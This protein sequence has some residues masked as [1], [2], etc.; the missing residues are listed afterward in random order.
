MAKAHEELKKLLAEKPGKAFALDLTRKAYEWADRI[1]DD[2]INYRIF[3]ELTVRYETGE[4]TRLG[5]DKQEHNRFDAV[6]FIQP[7]YRALNQNQC[8]TVGIEL[9]NSKADLVADKKMNKYI[10]WTDF[11]FIGVPADLTEDAIKKAEEVSLQAF[12]ENP[13]LGKDSLGKSMVGVFD[14]ENGFIYKMPARKQSVPVENR[15]KIQ[16]QVIYNVLFNDLKTIKVKFEE[17]DVVVLPPSAAP[18]TSAHERSAPGTSASGTPTTTGE[19]PSEATGST[20][21][22]TE[23]AS[24]G[25]KPIR[26]ASS[27]PKGKEGHTEAGNAESGTVSESSTVKTTLDEQFVAARNEKR[28]ENRARREELARNLVERNRQLTDR[29]KEQLAGLS[30]RDQLVFWCVRDAT[31]HGGIN[32]IDIPD[33]IGQSPASINRSIKRL[34]ERELVVLD[35]V[36]KYGK[37]KVLGDA[38]KSSRCVTCRLN[39]ECQGTALLCGSYQAA[40]TD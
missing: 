27:T 1:P 31:A 35:G 15:L 38:L 16:E 28:A 37:F 24:D 22:G 30:E 19:M 25:S 3:E 33:T 10:G 32:G 39:E 20:K 4:K 17:I 23:L 6:F 7:G 8:F 21:S 34:K 12:G 9:K 26:A 13:A 29:T 14:V 40:D 5:L 11:F 2:V 36:P 18:K